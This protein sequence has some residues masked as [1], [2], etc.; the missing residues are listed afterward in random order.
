MNVVIEIATAIFLV[1]AVLAIA[2]YF[3]VS[4]VCIPAVILEAIVRR[5]KSQ[6][7]GPVD[8]YLKKEIGIGTAICAV[9]FAVIVALNL[10][11]R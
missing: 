1:I 5:P 6:P 7:A 2:P 11:G 3:A 10:F 4:A 8:P 9:I